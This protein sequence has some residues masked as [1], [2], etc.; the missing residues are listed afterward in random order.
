MSGLKLVNDILE[1]NSHVVVSSLKDAYDVGVF[2]NTVN[3]SDKST[4]SEI[5]SMTLTLKWR[6][7]SRMAL[8]D[9]LPYHVSQSCELAVGITE[10]TP[11]CQVLGGFSVPV[12]SFI[13][14][15]SRS[16]T[17]C[18]RCSLTDQGSAVHYRHH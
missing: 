13:I 14:C 11:E 7:T 3:D 15:H 17:T 16:V 10:M 12:M 18:V 9:H 2:V 8:M 5:T 1:I 4:I 6:L